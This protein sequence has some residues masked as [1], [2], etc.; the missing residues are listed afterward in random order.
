MGSMRYQTYQDKISSISYHDLGQDRHVLAKML[1][2][3]VVSDPLTEGAQGHFGDLPRGRVCPGE[4]CAR[5]SIRQSGTRF[6]EKMSAK[7]I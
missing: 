3:P 5:D 4:K 7:P 6:T 1:S 2:L